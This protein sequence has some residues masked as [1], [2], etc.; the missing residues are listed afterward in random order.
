MAHLTTFAILIQVPNHWGVQWI[1]III[2]ALK[3]VPV[4]LFMDNVD[5]HVGTELA[6]LEYIDIFEIQI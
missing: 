3:K 6:K 4:H 1:Q 2:A 5:G